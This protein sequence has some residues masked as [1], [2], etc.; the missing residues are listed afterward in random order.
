MVE[1][2]LL[3]YLYQKKIQ[4]NLYEYKQVHCVLFFNQI[5][6]S[7][8]VFPLLI[9]SLWKELPN[10]KQNYFYLFFFSYKVKNYLCKIAGYGTALRFFF[11]TKNL[12]VSI[13]LFN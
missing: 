1:T 8:I 6:L 9:L 5:H 12:I 3:L 10:I 4:Y 7:I 11:V 2:V 13:Y